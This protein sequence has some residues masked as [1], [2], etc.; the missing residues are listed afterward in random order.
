M[1]S[2]ISVIFDSTMFIDPVTTSK[3]LALCLK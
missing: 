1:A 2:L 3:Y